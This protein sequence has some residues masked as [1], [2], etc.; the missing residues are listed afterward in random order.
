MDHESNI[1]KF[2]IYKFL[3]GFF[4]IAPILI[5][6]YLS[7][8]ISYFQL[9][10][11]ASIGL[12]T[13]MLFEIPSGTFADLI[14]RKIS[15]SLGMFLVAIQ[16][17]MVGYGNSYSFFLF[18]AV[19]GGIGWS[20]VSGADIALLYDSLKKM[21]KEKLFQNIN[22]KA[23]SYRYWGMIIASIS[24]AYIY[25]KFNNIVFLLNAI[26]FIIASLIFLTLKET[27]TKSKLNLK[28][29]IKH[30]QESFKYLFSNSKLLWFNLFSIVS[31]SFIW[32]FHDL[33]RQ[34][35][36]LNI[37]FEIAT[38]GILASILTITR[39]ITAANVHF[40]EKK[41]GEMKSMYFIIIFQSLLF[42]FIGFFQNKFAFLLLIFLYSIWTFQEVV[43]DSY[44]QNNMNSKQRATL[45]SINSFLNSAFLLIGFLL[46]GYII[47]LTSINYLIY[48]LSFTSLILGLILLSRKK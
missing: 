20:L 14:G 48:G 1:W 12:L 24:G 15:V 36:Y 34:P 10:L 25:S 37:G 30:I 29:Q 45:V 18:G 21:K 28:N 42:A 46:V 4:L 43:L 13:T 31:G 11:I 17:L 3:S 41:L 47:D 39:S 44:L 8:N 32:I 7:T 22:G 35:Y 23:K 33:I 9:S 6:F 2:Y 19:L 40:L 38:F 16:H 26:I 5:I 27:Q